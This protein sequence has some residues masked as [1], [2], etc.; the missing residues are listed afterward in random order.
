MHWF[1]MYMYCME[2]FINYSHSNKDPQSIDFL[3]SNIFSVSSYTQTIFEVSVTFF[4]RRWFYLLKSVKLTSKHQCVCV[5]VHA[6]T[7]MHMC[8]CMLVTQSCS[9]LCLWN[10]PSK[11]TGVGCHSLLLGIFPTQGSNLGLLHCR[12]IL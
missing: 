2:I 9:T 3:N 12:R 1:T 5:C 6:C 7:H 10:S 8:V 4:K 11:N